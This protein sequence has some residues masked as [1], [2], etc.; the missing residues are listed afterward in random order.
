MSANKNN[1]SA[2]REMTPEELSKTLRSDREELLNLR[3]RKN[4]GQVDNPARIR[5]L[6]R[7]IARLE[8]VAREKSAAR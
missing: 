3:L 2:I 1:A 5:T 6:R 4:T 8:T 7:E